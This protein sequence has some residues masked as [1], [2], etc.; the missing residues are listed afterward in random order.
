M[1]TTMYEDLRNEVLS[2]KGM[3]FGQVLEL[4]DKYTDLIINTDARMLGVHKRISGYGTW[5]ARIDFAN[6]YHFGQK[7]KELL[8]IDLPSIITHDEDKEFTVED[9]EED[10]QEK[11]VNMI[12]DIQ[13]ESCE[14]EYENKNKNNEEDKSMK[15]IECKMQDVADYYNKCDSLDTKALEAMI[16]ANGWVSDCDTEWGVCHNDTERV[17]INDEGQAVVVSMEKNSALAALMDVKLQIAV[18]GWTIPTNDEGSGSAGVNFLTDTEAVDAYIRF[19]FTGD[20][21]DCPNTDSIEYVPVADFGDTENEV[22]DEIMQYADTCGLLRD[23]VL[24]F[25]VCHEHYDME[26]TFYITH[27]RG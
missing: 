22:L 13:E 5:K 24:G 12:Q 26:Y 3:A 21:T 6:E 11:L 4:A 25:I 20:N 9:W 2:N 14:D 19:A 1:A 8:T 16:E 7:I 10:I 27:I 15:T 17:I 23:D 18:E